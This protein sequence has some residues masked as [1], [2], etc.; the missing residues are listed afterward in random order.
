MLNKIKAKLLSLIMRSKLYNKL[1][2]DIIPYIRF[3][4]YYTQPTNKN[5]DKWGALM[6]KGYVV[7]EPGHIILTIDE[8]KLT[9]KLISKFT[10]EEGFSHAAFCVSKDG[11]FEVAEMTHTNFTKSTWSDICYES[12]RV[13][14]LKCDTFDQEYI[15]EML[16]M[17]DDFLH[18]P[19]D[20]MFKMGIEALSCAELCYMYDFEKRMD[21]KLDPILG[22]DPYISPMG[23][24]KGKN[25]RVVWDSDKQNRS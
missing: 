1:L 19:Y 20:N 18:L 2:T 23:L 11:D 17:T 5:F 3:S 8:K 15:N 7:L 4:T 14:I 10:G 13:V 22:L 9:T 16:K 12:T 21:V 24:F 25:I 6:L